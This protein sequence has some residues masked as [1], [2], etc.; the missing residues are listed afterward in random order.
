MPKMIIAIDG[1]VMNEIELAKER[2]TIGRRPH[3]DVVIDNLAI[4]GEHAVLHMPEPGGPVEIED[5]QSTNGTYVNGEPVQRHVLRSGDVIEMGKYKIRFMQDADQADV[6]EHTLV[7]KPGMAPPRNQ[8]TRPAPLA[9]AMPLTATPLPAVAAPT[10]AA[11]RVLTGPAAGRE[12]A[13][14]KVVTTLGKPG[15]AVASI[16][17]RHDESFA[18]AHVE[19]LQSATLNGTALGAEGMPLRHGD[20]IELAGTAMEFVIV[21]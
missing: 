18:L 21:S 19:G 13:L 12:V 1:V 14:T 11:I 4:S 5:L 15:V 7:F 17:R 10:A 9:G 20:R 2:T 8:S 3:N 16:T 6:Y